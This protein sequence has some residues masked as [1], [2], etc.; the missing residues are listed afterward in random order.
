MGFLMVAAGLCPLELSAQTP[1][2]AVSPDP[3]VDV[4]LTSFDPSMLFYDYSWRSF[5]ALN[6]PA[7][8]G[9]ANRG[10][11]DRTRT[12][13]D[14]A[15]PRVW[16]T[17]KSRYKIFQPGGV[18]PANWD[19]FDGKNPCGDGVTN[20]TTT[21]SSFSPFADFNQADFGFTLA[22]PL[23]SQNGTY[24]RF[25]VRVNKEEFE[26]IKD[27]KWYIHA[28]LP[29]HDNPSSFKD[30]SIEIKAAWR[31]VAQNETSESTSRY[32]TIDDAQVFDP[33]QAKCVKQKI[34]LIGFHIV[35]KTPARP[36]WIWSSFEHVDNVPPR[37]TEPTPPVSVPFSLN[38]PEAE[39]KTADPRPPVSAANPPVDATPMQVVRERDIRP[40]VMEVNKSYWATD[41]IKGT[42]WQ[43]Y[44]LVATQWPAAPTADVLTDLGGPQPN[45]GIRANTTM[46]TFFQKSGCMGCH[47]DA[48]FEGRDFVM[49]PTF[50]AF[51]PDIVGP[52]NAF[53]QR[54]ENAKTNT[55]VLAADPVIKR[56]INSMKSPPDE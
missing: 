31:I 19:S 51:R 40:E 10:Q 41:G 23:V 4:P 49:F 27:N 45:V 5:I 50:D 44:M 33:A 48:A 42:V 30:G 24:L 6:W 2:P 28:N 46:E 29:T 22:S 47:L 35:A 43:N 14:V 52:A 12:F 8:S 1:T 17:W 34:A 39:Q 11:P 15:G 36:E 21:L 38:N 53:T 54:S 26:T 25:E 9:A 32:Y 55:E 37:T 20:E 7:M 3:V 18:D 56:L 13:A 16:G